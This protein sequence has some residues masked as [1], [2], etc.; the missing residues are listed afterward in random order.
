M[1]VFAALALGA[2]LLSC[3]TASTFDDDSGPVDSGTSDMG[4]AACPAMQKR[5]SN[6]CT[7]P[8]KDVNNCGSCGVKCKAGQ[9][10]AA[11]KCSDACSMPLVLC[12]QFC[13]D[14]NADHENCGKCGMGCSASQECK[15]KVCIKQCPST[16]SLCDPDCV[17]LTTDPNHC[18][19]CNTACG[20][21]ESCIGSLCCGQGQTACNG[22]CVNTQ[23]DADNCGACGFAC[24]G[25][26]AYCGSGK[27]LAGCNPTGQRLTFN[28][29][30]SKTANGCW[31]TG[32][33][34]NTNNYS[35][36]PNNGLNFAGNGQDAVCSGTTACV[37]HVGILTYQS[38]S[39]CQG[40]W[41]I[42]CDS[43]KVGSIVT[44]N[45]AC[46]GTAMNNTCNVAFTPR[47][48]STIRLVATGGGSGQACCGGGMPDAMLTG[49]SAW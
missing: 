9:Y 27:C 7:D 45:K 2:V 8:Q 1:R 47:Q 36:S 41:D 35:W 6:V 22:V 14:L 21:N 39:V 3:A 19:D 49:V 33:P 11:G 42:Y 32:N 12:G 10:C 5:C 24:G 16:L 30:Q 20:M 31:N 17:N 48:C 34:C 44:T 15:S 40:A 26:T 29:L 46:Q 13:V 18:G 23:F 43:A 38:S 28:T 25:Q 4:P 37:G